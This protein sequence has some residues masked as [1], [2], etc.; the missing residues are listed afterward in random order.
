MNQSRSTVIWSHIDQFM[1]KS[2]TSWPTLAAEVR[3][4]YE[5]LVPED[6]RIIHFSNNKD[7]YARMRNDAQTLRRFRRGYE[8]ALWE[9]DIPADMEEAMVLALGSLGYASYG[10]LMAE[11]AERYGLLAAAIPGAGAADDINGLGCA[12]KETG[13]ALAAVSP[14]LQGDNRIDENDSPEQLRE[15]QLQ[16]SQAIAA[17]ASL[18]AR[19]VH[20]L[21]G[22]EKKQKGRHLT[23]AK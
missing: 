21:D 5:R 2:A 19:I 1:N 3:G 10:T 18:N 23:V 8:H 4:H 14:L 11:L 9:Y 6:Q 17:L 12:V 16:V 13:E 7:A 20:A 22:A 15:A